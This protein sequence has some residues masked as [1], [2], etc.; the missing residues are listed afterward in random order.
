[1][2]SS[3]LTIEDNELADVALL[4]LV[5]TSSA[6]TVVAI[7]QGPMLL[8]LPYSTTSLLLLKLLPL[9][10]E[11]ISMPWSCLETAPPRTFPTCSLS[12]IGACHSVSWRLVVENNKSTSAAARSN[13]DD[14]SVSSPFGDSISNKE[15]CSLPSSVAGGRL[16]DETV[17]F[18]SNR[19]WSGRIS[20]VFGHASCLVL[21]AGA[22]SIVRW[23]IKAAQRLCL[24]GRRFCHQGT[25]SDV[26]VRSL[27]ALDFGSSCTARV[28]RW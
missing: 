14:V 3:K 11:A 2:W 21:A 12:T 16:G 1:M 27:S 7:K 8:L 25:R 15:S 23:R 9:E 24:E 10:L 4:G 17:A 20:M 18:A 19:G 13:V 26:T 6:A 28:A 22:S 5:F